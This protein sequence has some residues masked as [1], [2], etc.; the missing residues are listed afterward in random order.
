MMNYVLKPAQ[1]EHLHT[2]LNW[3]QTADELCLW[4]GSALSFPPSV[5][6]TWVEIGANECNSFVLSSETGEVLGFVQ[7]LER[8]SNIHLARIIVSPA[9]RGKGLGRILCEQLIRHV[10]SVHH[11]EKITLNVFSHNTVAISLYTSLGFMIVSMQEDKG[12]VGMALD[13]NGGLG[14]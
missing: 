11:P 13:P 1:K 2:V 10:V 8:S 12:L 5:E 3:V 4:G 9:V 14:V 7:T 6:T